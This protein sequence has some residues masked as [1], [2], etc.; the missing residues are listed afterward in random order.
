MKG[1]LSAAQ[2]FNFLSFLLS[3]GWIPYTSIS[4]LW[5][6]ITG[7]NKCPIMLKIRHTF[8]LPWCLIYHTKQSMQQHNFSL[9]PGSLDYF[10]ELPSRLDCFFKDKEVAASSSKWFGKFPT[11]HKIWW[12]SI[13]SPPPFPPSCLTIS[14]SYDTVGWGGRSLGSKLSYWHPGTYVGHPVICFI[15]AFYTF[16]AVAFPPPTHPHPMSLLL[17][18]FHNTKCHYGMWERI[19]L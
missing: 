12:R 8:F 10:P 19:I 11:Y 17:N 5:I 9:F 1:W 16:S 14:G 7:G 3:Q 15:P 6:P 18:L 2:V 4:C 13:L